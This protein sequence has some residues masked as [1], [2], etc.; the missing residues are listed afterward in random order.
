M[1][2]IFLSVLLVLCCMFS[3]FSM[4]GCA[5]ENVTAEA[6]ISVVL[7]IGN[8]M[9]TVNGSTLEIDP[10]RGTMPVVISDR[11]LVPI[12]A[13][14]EAMGGT[15]SWDEAAQT[16]VLG[17]NNN[18]I[19]LTIDNPIAYFNN[20]AYTLDVAPAT[21]NDRT[22]LPIRFIAERFSFHVD[23]NGE[24]QRITI[25]KELSNSE[26][27]EEP[28]ITPEPE[29]PPA[30]T[31]TRALT[32]YF[33]ATGNTEALAETVAQAAGADLARIIPA[34]PYT[35]ADLNYN[36]NSCRANQ[37]LNSDARPAIQPLEVDVS[38]YDVILLGYPIWWGQCPPVVRTFL[39]SYDLSGKT[40]MPFCTS[41]STGISGS[42]SKIR[43]LAPNSTVT[44]GFRG[45]SSTGAA[46]IDEWLSDNGFVKETV[47]EPEMMAETK[48]R[49]SWDNNE[50]IV[51]L[52][53]NATTQDFL[54]KLPMTVT[55]EDYNNTEKISYLE[56]SLV[57]DE[58]AAGCDPIP[59]TVALYA[60]WGN[61]SI[62]YKDW[63]YSNDL[64]PM[65]QI[66]TGLD[67][68][69]A[70]NGDVA[71]HIERME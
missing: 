9:M 62:F 40:I 67:V 5:A 33:S 35:S 71:V 42:L 69:T 14:I 32:I 22:M 45:T 66:E 61:L 18:E 53:D 55:L 2:K 11:T 70:I 23:W 57:K 47:S 3:L 65:G 64:I 7:Q 28:V 10:G 19:R 51:V 41:G 52:K 15:V 34:E 44:D 20:E 24:E 6:N 38:Q 16:A 29:E 48:V 1:M 59:G 46:Q 4:T 63:S 31:N 27:T 30:P 21:M 26:P 12:R 56:E 43:E 25:T 54:S 39:D 50:V 13:I 37:E 49:L 68:L 36:N 60:P 8:P 17:Y 58:T